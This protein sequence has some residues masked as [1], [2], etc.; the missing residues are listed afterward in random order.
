MRISSLKYKQNEPIR[1]Y[2]RLNSE[3]N[4]LIIDPKPFS[5][6]E[7]DGVHLTAKHLCEISGFRL[8]FTKE[9]KELIVH[10]LVAGM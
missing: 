8:L 7:S 4:P 10:H 9:I 6:P 3:R 5:M 1:Y 2:E